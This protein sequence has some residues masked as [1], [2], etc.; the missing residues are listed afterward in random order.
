MAKKRKLIVLSN[1][2]YPLEKSWSGTTYSL[3]KAL[4]R[5]YDVEIKSLAIGRWLKLLARL[6]HVPLFGLLFGALYDFILKNKA[7]IIIG[8]DKTIPV[9]EI[10]EDV[11]VKNPYF[12]YQDMTYHAGLV[13]K[14]WKKKYSFIYQAAGNDVLSEGEIHRRERRQHDE[15]RHASA[16]FFMSRWVK[17]IMSDF[18]PDVSHKMIHIGGG[19]NID[20]NKIDLSQKKGNKFLF[21]GRDFERK[22]GDLVIEAFKIL[23]AQYMPNAELHMAGCQPLKNVD[24]IVYYG[25]VNYDKVSELLNKCDVFCMPSRFEAYG[26]VF[27]E[28]LIYGLPCI[29]RRF[30]EMPHF[31]EE[32]K[33]GTLIEG[34][35]P[36]I[37]A[38]KM[39]E[40][41]SDKEMIAGI[42]SKQATYI[43]KYSWDS[44]AK[45]AK[46]IIDNKMHFRRR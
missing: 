8:K 24:G 40:T 29:G 9:L 26:L 44:V 18:H 35:D 28:S 27:V 7:N 30:F 3:T 19:T 39:F 13:V 32:G 41:I 1:W 11:K 10:C 2:T 25:D 38:E 37:L 15:Y 42:Q 46:T 14:E 31:I 5:Y 20:V 23:K 4:E 21:I 34:E 45:K 12:T 33:E 16:V 36:K 43:E 22:A 6:S 17:D